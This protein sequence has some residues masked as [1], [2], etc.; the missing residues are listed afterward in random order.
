MLQERRR[1]ERQLV[2]PRPYVAVNG[3]SSG[4]MLYDVSEGGMALDILGP[5][6][7]SDNVLLN[8]D[9]AEIS[10]HFEAKGR[11]TWAHETIKT[12]LVSSS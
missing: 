9:L 5:R 2:S 10:E 12:E 4:G 7:A 1:H 8:F 6:P 3:S 11:I